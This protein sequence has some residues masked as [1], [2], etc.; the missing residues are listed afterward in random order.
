MWGTAIITIVV[1][2]LPFVGGSGPGLA[3]P[4]HADALP[5]QATDRTNAPVGTAGLASGTLERREAYAAAG[6]SCPAAI[7]G[8]ASDRVGGTT[9][10]LGVGGTTQDDL[11]EFAAAFNAIRIENCLEPISFDNFSWDSCMEH[12]LF[13]MAE[14]PSTDPLSAWGH[15]GSE[16]SDGV[17]SV[18]CDGNLAGGP[19]NTG[20]TVAY[21]W[22]VSD[23]HRASLYRPGADSA[24]ACIAF[25]M[26]H[27]GVP[28]E[29]AG[30]T[31]AAARWYDC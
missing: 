17:P 8:T 28:N 10:P 22:W 29:A 11:A 15:L 20:S 7:D 16:R 23:A 9:S 13:W 1:L 24:G 14:D 31:R 30:F 21:K 4:A 6:Q 3:A 18:G 2:A 27:G 19:D 26:T 25:A 5:T 12:R